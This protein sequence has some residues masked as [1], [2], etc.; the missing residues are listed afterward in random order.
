M[1]TDMD[2]FEF[3]PAGFFVGRDYQKTTLNIVWGVNQYLICKSRLVSGG[4]LVDILNITLIII[5]LRRL[6]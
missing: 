2:C 6:F 3:K 1:L 4:N 5:Q